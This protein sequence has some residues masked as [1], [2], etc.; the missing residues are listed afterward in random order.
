MEAKARREYILKTLNDNSIPKT[1][2]E[3]AEK[4]GVTRQVIVKDIA[5][6][7]AKG[8]EILS[9]PKG[10]IILKEQSHDIEKVIAVFHNAEQME[11]ELKTIVKYGATIKNV[12]IEH[13]L[14]G[15]I[16]AMMMIKTLVDIE[17]FV[18]KFKEHN[19]E[20]LSALTG[21][22]HLHTICCNDEE[23]MNKIIKEL[24]VKGYLI[25][26]KEES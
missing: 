9:T 18:N 19:A 16:T 11:D 12:I 22:V 6:L 1:G 14:Y 10:Y 21:G 26:D 8:I 24:K 17:N 4:L 13:A 7:R 23:C 2:Q 3:L 25:S 20:P 15:E 5:I